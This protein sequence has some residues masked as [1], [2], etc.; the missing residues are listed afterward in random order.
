MRRARMSE[1]QALIS[2][3][4]SS[5]FVGRA[6]FVRARGSREGVEQLALANERWKRVFDIV[7]WVNRALETTRGLAAWCTVTSPLTYV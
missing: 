3:A 1:C 5:F 6:H 2:V 7:L 4:V